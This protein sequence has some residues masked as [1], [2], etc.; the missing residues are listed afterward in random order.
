MSDFLHL[1]EYVQ[2]AKEEDLFVIVRP[3]PFICAEFEFGGFPS[4]LLREKEL[5]VRTSNS[6]FMKYVSRYFSVLLPL[7]AAL[8]FIN[9]GSIIM[10]QVE[11]E[12]ANS[13]K[14]DS[15][16]VKTLRQEMLKNGKYY[17]FLQ[18]N[19]CINSTFILI[20]NLICS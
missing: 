7:L 3:G 11:N 4:W 10:F 1:K 16:Y 14:H 13:R 20:F 8:Q 9:G 12:Y 17:F 18:G 5:E 6:I 15:A 2:T 19:N